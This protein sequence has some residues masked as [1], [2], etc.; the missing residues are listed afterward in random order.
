MCGSEKGYVPKTEVHP[1]PFKGKE[2]EI[3]CTDIVG[4]ECGDALVPDGELQKRLDI[5]IAKYGCNLDGTPIEPIE[6]IP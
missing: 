5:L 2:F 4:T 3:E 6:P 1:V